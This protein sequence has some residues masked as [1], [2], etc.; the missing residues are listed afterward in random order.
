MFMIALI[1][2][3][4]FLRVNFFARLPPPLLFSGVR[5]LFLTA[6]DEL[7]KD[8][9]VYQHRRVSFHHQPAVETIY[10]QKPLF[11]LNV[12]LLAHGL[13]LHSVVFVFLL[14]IRPLYIMVC[15]SC[16]TMGIY[17]FPIS[18]QGPKTKYRI[19]PVE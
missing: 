14:N 7:P 4:V 1:F 15:I 19:L 8:E 5:T 17:L 11:L 2:L 18:N 16:Y 3:Y 9:L 13:Y 6:S 10:S 12:P